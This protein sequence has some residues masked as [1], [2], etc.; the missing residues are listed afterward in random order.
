MLGNSFVRGLA[1]GFGHISHSGNSIKWPVPLLNGFWIKEELELTVVPI[2]T[3][4][5]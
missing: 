2:F 4:A 3:D 1:A 5:T